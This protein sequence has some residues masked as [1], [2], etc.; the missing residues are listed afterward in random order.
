MR[1]MV[2]GLDSAVPD[3]VFNQWRDE[4]HTLRSLAAGGMWGE[5]RSTHPPITVPAWSSMMSGLDPGQLGFYGFRN[6]KDY[7]YDRY[8]IANARVVNAHRVW[9][10]L[11]QAGK[12]V[13]LVGVPQTYPVKPINGC[14]VTDFLTPSTQHEYTFPEN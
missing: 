13:I 11:S 12:K 3:L 14:I 1:L 9:D 8:S 6:R 10:I 7:S 5:L 4:L 2:I